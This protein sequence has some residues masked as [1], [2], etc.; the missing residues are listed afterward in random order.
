MEEG[1][2]RAAVRAAMVLV[3]SFLLLLYIPNKLLTYLALHLV[4][5]ARDLAMGVY[6]VV[7]VVVTTAIF[8]RLQRRNGT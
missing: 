2:G 5:T 6:L 1:W 3:A 4:P 8:L 7:S